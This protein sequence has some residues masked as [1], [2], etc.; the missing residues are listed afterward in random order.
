M[1]YK[2]KHPNVIKILGVYNNKL[3]KTTYLVYALMEVG[4]TDWEKE[5]KSYSDKHIEYTESEL[6]NIIKQLAFYLKRK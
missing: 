3:D 5:I 1:C 2:I 6:I 4:L